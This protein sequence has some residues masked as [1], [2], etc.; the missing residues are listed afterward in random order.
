MSQNE[1]VLKYNK[2]QCKKIEPPNVGHALLYVPETKRYSVLV[3]KNVSHK[4]KLQPD[5]QQV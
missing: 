5:K 3:K 4:C 1:L 2:K